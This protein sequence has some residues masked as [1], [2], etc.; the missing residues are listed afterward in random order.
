M[1]E[2]VVDVGC[3]RSTGRGQCLGGFCAGLRQFMVAVTRLLMTMLTSWLPAAANSQ[4]IAPSSIASHSTSSIPFSSIPRTHAVPFTSCDIFNSANHCP[5]GTALDTPQMVTENGLGSLCRV[6]D[7]HEGCVN[8]LCWNSTGT[9]LAS[10]S[11]DC[12]LVIWDA[13]LGREVE[14]VR[15]IHHANMSQARCVD[16][17]G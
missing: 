7:S 8:R 17:R 11:D 3:W 9:K 14:K 4:L 15:R 13:A 10:V 1:T 2:F 5:R 6:L 12:S 16:A